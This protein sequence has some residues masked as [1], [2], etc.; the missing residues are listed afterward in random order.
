MSRTVNP[1]AFWIIALFAASAFAQTTQPFIDVSQA[2]APLF[3]DPVTHG[4]TDPFVIW[5]PVKNEWFMYYTQR[6]SNLQ[7]SHAFDW[8]HGSPIGIATS[9][10]GVH[11]TYLGLCQGDQNLADPLAV[12]GNGPEQGI[13]WWA[14]CFL[15]VDDKFHMWIVQ[16]DGVYTH[17]TGKR[18]ILH[19]TSDDGITWKYLSTARLSSE[20]VIDP[21][22]YRVGNLWYM[23]YKDEAADSHTYVSQSADLENWTN[24]HQAEPDGSQEAPFAFRWHNKWWLIV[25]A[26]SGRGLRIYTSENGIDNFKYVT[27]IL[28]RPDGTRPDD[29]AVGHH[30]GMVIQGEGDTQQ[31]LVYYFTEFRRHEYMQLAELEMG[32]DGT[33]FCNRNKYAA[34]T[35]P[36]GK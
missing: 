16:V 13:T 2:P 33:V 25:N 17:W 23:V 36:A 8:V 3:D 10:D 26:V 22:V 24:A 1:V 14:P 35:Q 18:H 30:P 31:C 7:N 11:W 32:P 21:T 12:R 9:A 15:R 34:A 28:A 29:N 6:R 20:R 5:N 4:G 27:T 19:F